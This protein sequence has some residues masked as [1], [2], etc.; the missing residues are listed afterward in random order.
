MIHAIVE[1]R[2]ASIPDNDPI[3]YLFVAKVNFPPGIVLRPGMSI[4][5]GRIIPERIPIHSAFCG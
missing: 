2:I 3:D 4:G 1:I 5:I